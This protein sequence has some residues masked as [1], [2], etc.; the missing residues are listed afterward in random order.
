MNL[1]PAPLTNPKN[2]IAFIKN[3]TACV[4]VFPYAPELTE[5]EKKSIDAARRVRVFVY[6]CRDAPV[7]AGHSGPS[8]PQDF[9]MESVQW[10]IARATYLSSEILHVQQ[11]RATPES[12]LDALLDLDSKADNDDHR[13]VVTFV[14]D[15]AF[16]GDDVALYR[17]G[18]PAAKKERRR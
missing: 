9:P 10:A 8:K 3:G 17:P 5:P 7:P 1:Q 16:E 14:A 13:C 11:P 18:I 12:L 15:H 4:V 2:L 6:G